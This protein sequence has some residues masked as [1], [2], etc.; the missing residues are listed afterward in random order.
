MNLSQLVDGISGDHLETATI[1]DDLQS[2]PDLDVLLGQLE[3]AHDPAALHTLG[4]SARQAHAPAAQ[5]SLQG[6][7][8]A[9]ACQVDAAAQPPDAQQRG[10]QA[11]P[12]TGDTRDDAVRSGE[13]APPPVTDESAPQP[14]RHPQD[15]ERGMTHED[16]IAPQPM[17][18]AARKAAPADSSHSQGV[19]EHEARRSR[20]GAL[21]LPP[22]DA[23]IGSITGPIGDPSV[24]AM[25]ADVAEATA[26]GSASAP[27]EQQQQG[28]KSEAARNN[29]LAAADGEGDA[30]EAFDREAAATQQ[31]EG[32]LEERVLRKERKAGKV[33]V[34]RLTIGSEHEAPTFIGQVSL[35]LYL[36]SGSRPPSQTHAAS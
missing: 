24:G 13:P 20:S 7:R 15:Q 1:P 3:G 29:V 31:Q 33:V 30:I 10:D 8:T 11:A 36:V 2:L 28:Q 25:D 17:D 14:A 4:P 6:D 27:P 12:T 35:S 18:A 5:G 19:Q 32:R 23:A 34:P 26:G 22:P 16:A 9:S 21:V